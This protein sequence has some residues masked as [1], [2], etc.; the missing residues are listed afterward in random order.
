MWFLWPCKVWI[1][2]FATRSHSQ[3]YLGH[4]PERRESLGYGFL[5]WFPPLFDRFILPVFQH[6]GFSAWF[7]MPIELSGKSSLPR[8]RGCRRN[9]FKRCSVAWLSLHLI[10]TSWKKKIAKIHL[11][12]IKNLGCTGANH[13][14]GMWDGQRLCK[15]YSPTAVDFWDS[16][17]N[18]GKGFRVC[19]TLILTIIFQWSIVFV[20]RPNNLTKFTRVC[21]LSAWCST[22]PQ[23]RKSSMKCNILRLHTRVNF[24]LLLDKDSYLQLSKW[25]SKMMNSTRQPFPDEVAHWRTR[26]SGGE[27]F[28]YW[29][30][31]VWRS[32]R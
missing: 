28:S 27:L 10:S 20:N 11:C 1:R 22:R 29:Q 2:G 16:L 6:A 17:R 31:K 9:F 13:A 14:F 30:N 18:S 7:Y 25:L 24:S 12:L 21:N 15:R 23:S 4:Q 19:L 8:K 26:V 3:S 5:A 32:K